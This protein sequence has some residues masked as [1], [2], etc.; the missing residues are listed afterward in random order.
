VAEYNPR[1]VNPAYAKVSN[2]RSRLASGELRDYSAQTRDKAAA[3][4]IDSQA[5]SVDRDELSLNHQ[6]RE[7]SNTQQ[8]PDPRGRAEALDRPSIFQQAS[9]NSLQRNPRLISAESGLSNEF[10]EKNF[11]Q[12]QERKKIQAE[13]RK[14]EVAS[15]LLNQILEK[16]ERDRKKKMDNDQLEML[17]EQKYLNDLK[18]IQESST[19]E[20]KK[21]FN[22]FAEDLNDA[23]ISADG[24]KNYPPAGAAGSKQRIPS[25]ADRERLPQPA[26]GSKSNL[27]GS[28]RVSLQKRVIG[29]EY[30]AANRE[31]ASPDMTFAREDQVNDYVSDQPYNMSN[32]DALAE[33]LYAGQLNNDRALQYASKMQEFADF[34]S[35]EKRRELRMNTNLLYQQIID[36]RA[37][38]S[39]TDNLKAQALQSY[40]N[41]RRNLEKQNLTLANE[42]GN[43]AS[44]QDRPDHR[45][46]RPYNPANW[47]ASLEPDAKLQEYRKNGLVIAEPFLGK[48][49]QTN[50]ASADGLLLGSE[51]T[52]IPLKYQKVDPAA[53]DQ[54]ANMND[55][56]F[57]RMV[58]QEQ[59][60][61]RLKEKYKAEPKETRLEDLRRRNLDFDDIVAEMVRE[62]RQI[63]EEDIGLEKQSKRSELDADALDMIIENLHNDDF[64]AKLSIPKIKP[65]ASDPPADKPLEDT[66][67]QP[68]VNNKIINMPGFI[69]PELDSRDANSKHKQ[70]PLADSEDLPLKKDTSEAAPPEQASDDRPR[71][72]A[73]A[74]EQAEEENTQQQEGGEEQQ[75]ADEEQNEE[76]QDDKAGEEEDQAEEEQSA[77]NEAEEEN[78]ADPAEEHQQAATPAH[79]SSNG[80]SGETTPVSGQQQLKGVLSSNTL[81]KSD[82]SRGMKKKVTFSE[83]PHPAKEV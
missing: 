72:D 6:P 30:S 67:Q 2:S 56:D 66:D 41:L 28:S 74:E 39:Y 43:L 25:A 29:G 57:N 3:Q 14:H 32:V 5:Y 75:A 82:K 9:L 18:K 7:D 54:L 78:G 34:K 52:L 59:R 51:T 48:P 63:Y 42:I 83:L 45:K 68:S 76:E 61:D 53:L 26:E 40:D 64:R 65:L 4:G 71:D 79:N 1:P 55:E 77:D 10:F 16:K 46:P 69:N 24:K 37:E 20:K 70:Q 19:V 62:C 15:E 35:E 11:G 22:I 58:G 13:G 80:A 8:R 73:A 81:N 27:G 17:A 21:P 23:E 38:K 60:A 33:E 12:A 36:L 44:Q 47:K 50:T 49:R 31:E